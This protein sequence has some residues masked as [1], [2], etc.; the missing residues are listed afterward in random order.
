LHLERRAKFVDLGQVADRQ[1]PNEDAAISRSLQQPAPDET[2]ERRPQGVPAD[3]VLLGELHFAEVFAGLK[4]TVEN[5]PA[6]VVLQ[7]LH[8]RDSG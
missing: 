3:G 8:D 1:R 6:E 7:R 2:V 5:A 4:L